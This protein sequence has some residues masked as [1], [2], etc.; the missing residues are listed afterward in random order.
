M[1][2]P[3]PP[4]IIIGISV[5]ACQSFSL[6]FIYLLN[7]LHGVLVAFLFFFL[8]CKKVVYKYSASKYFLLFCV[9]L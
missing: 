7:G 3:P 9:Q 6:L 5:S 2:T 8:H 4:P 1:Q